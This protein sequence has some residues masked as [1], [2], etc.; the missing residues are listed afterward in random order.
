MMDFFQVGLVR[1]LV[2]EVERLRAQ[3]TRIRELH[4]PITLE[5]ITCGEDCEHED[6]KDCPRNDLEVCN[7][8]YNAA[9]E[10]DSYYGEHGITKDVAY[11]CSTIAA[12]DTEG[13]Q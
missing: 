6:E 5:V 13:E 8:C 1:E 3:E 10:V 9:I 2:A 7:H 12:L 4:R 11:P